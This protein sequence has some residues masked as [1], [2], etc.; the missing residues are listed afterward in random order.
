MAA[1]YDKALKRKDCS[2]VV[3]EEKEKGIIDTQTDSKVSAAGNVSEN[4]CYISS[5]DMRHPT[6]RR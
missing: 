5:P 6:L 2:G 4:P 3:D 1:I